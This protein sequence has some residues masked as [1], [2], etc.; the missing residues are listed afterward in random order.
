MKAKS[1]RTL[2]TFRAAHDRDTVIT[3][4]IK[5]ALESLLK[6]EGPEGYAYEANDPEGHPTFIKRAGISLTDLGMYREQFADHVV[7]LRNN[8]RDRGKRVW[9]ATIKA[10]KAARGE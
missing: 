1:P 7:E 6:D 5:A 8:S 9:F 2:A 4:K 3:N 10:A